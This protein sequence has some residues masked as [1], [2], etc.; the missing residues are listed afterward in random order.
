MFFAGLGAGWAIF[1]STTSPNMT[2]QQMQKMMADPNFN[3]Q[4]MSQ[5]R[6]NPQMMQNWHNQMMNDPQIRQQM[7]NMMMGNMTGMMHQMGRPFNPDLNPQQIT[8]PAI[9]GFN[10]LH[11]EAIRHVKPDGDPSKLEVVVHHHCKVY[12]DMTAAC[13][14]FPTGMGDQDKPYGIEYVVTAEQFAEL[15]EEEKA[16]WHYHKTE[17]PRAHATF[18]D[19]NESELA[20]VKPILDETYGKVFYFWQYG[21]KHPIGEPEV[22]VIQHLPEQP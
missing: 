8:Y 22:L 16:Y 2:P 17:F 5:F 1:Q 13:L 11:I 20:K 7:M 15:P 3:Q 4:M 6:N 9:F 14:L 19:M 10:D 12:D 21:D 18:P